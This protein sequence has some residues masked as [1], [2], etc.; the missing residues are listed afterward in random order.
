ME[1]TSKRSSRPLRS[2]TR[3]F[4][5]LRRQLLKART[6]L[7][8]QALDTCQ[9]S[10]DQVPPAD[11]IDLAVD[12]QEEA[13]GDLLTDRAY[14]KLQQIEQALLRMRDASYGICLSCRGNIPIQRLKV[15]PETIYCVECKERIEYSSSLRGMHRRS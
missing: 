7:L 13:F 10:C 5:S 9:R 4:E 15:Q 12:V 6:S 14:A 1:M 3:Q 8:D 11:P 2:R